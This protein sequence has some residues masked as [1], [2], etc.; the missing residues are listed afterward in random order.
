MKLFHGNLA[1]FPVLLTSRSKTDILIAY[2][3]FQKILGGILPMKHIFI[4]NPAAGK[5][6][7]LPSLLSSITY[8]CEELEADYQIYHTATVGDGIR[9]VSEFCEK[10]PDMPKRFYA[11]G[12]DGTL[13]EVLNGAVGHPNTEITVVPAGTGN[14]FT[15]TFKNPEYFADI[16]RQI[17]GK[18]EK[19]DLMKYGK[20]YALN[21]IN[22]GFDCDVVQ[23]V[24]EIKR[25]ALM[26]SKMAYATAVAEVFTK[27]FGKFF[28]VL[29]D[30]RE[31]VEREFMLCAIANA[32]FYGDGYQ[33]APLAMLNDGMM[34]L[35]L[36]DRVS[37]KEFVKVIPK[38]KAGAHISPEGESLYPFLRYQRCKKIVLESQNT[39]GLCADGEVFPL[40]SI[41]ITCEP[42][43]IA[44]S[45]P[46]GSFSSAIAK[47]KETF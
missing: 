17:L 34:E 3:N 31:L 44:F 29:I 10:H 47:N 18:A 22:L 38:Y 35:C 23:R 8:A 14:D 15:K 25:H 11:C 43:A 16:K 9:F 40:R 1:F 28:K 32:R 6:R 33:V 12:G 36:V 26:P 30:D 5:G 39:I 20:R 21:V 13:F 19:I 42:R 4:I 37:R 27:P 45:V 24:A 46:K 2:A 41:E 7:H